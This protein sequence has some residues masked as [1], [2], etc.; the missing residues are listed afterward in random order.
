MRRA[1][2]GMMIAAWV[3]IAAGVALLIGISW[4]VALDAQ[5][6]GLEPAEAGA[7]GDLHA[8][9][10]VPG[11]CLEDISADGAVSDAAI[12]DCD[13]PHRGEVITALGFSELRFPGDDEE[14]QRT[15]EH[16]STRMPDLGSGAS[17]VAWVPSADSWHRGDRTGLCI[18]TWD[19]AREGRVGPDRARTDE[20]AR[21]S[22]EPRDEADDQVA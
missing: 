22:E 19:S 14:A 8:M 5:S 4:S 6:R 16:C 9:Q 15:I 18:A 11:M 13:D 21:E 2:R 7:T 3:A 12:V 1:G 10:V 20:P 17:W